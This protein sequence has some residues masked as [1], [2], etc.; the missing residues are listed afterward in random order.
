[1]INAPSICMCPVLN[2]V[3][4]SRQLTQRCFAAI[5]LLVLPPKFT[6]ICCAM[7]CEVAFF[8]QEFPDA[9]PPMT[10]TVFGFIDTPGTRL[11][12]NDSAILMSLT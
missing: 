11:I 12:G 5:S 9:K 8:I 7:N 10:S 3:L 1:M 2:Y 4:P 6:G